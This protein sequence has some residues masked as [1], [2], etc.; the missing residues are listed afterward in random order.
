MVAIVIKVFPNPI[1]V[2]PKRIGVAFGSH[3]KNEIEEI[4]H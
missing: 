4:A 3:R 1:S 2:V